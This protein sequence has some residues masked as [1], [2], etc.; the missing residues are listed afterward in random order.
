VY[1][2]ICIIYR[3]NI[4]CIRLTFNDII[5][6]TVLNDDKTLVYNHTNELSVIYY[7]VGYSPDDYHTENDWNARL[8]LER[9][10]A[11]K[12]PNIGYHLAGAKKVQQV[13]AEK[14][15]LERFMTDSECALLRQVC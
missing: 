11:I 10:M 15:Q 13:L 3:H 9:S 5:T 2:I 4:Q 8:L 1:V 12:C 7:R 14:G 6:N